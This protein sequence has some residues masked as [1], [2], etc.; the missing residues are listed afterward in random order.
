[1]LPYKPVKGA[2]VRGGAPPG[3]RTPNPLIKSTKFTHS[4]RH[5][6]GLCLLWLRRRVPSKPQ[7]TGVN[8]QSNGQDHSTLD[9]SR[10]SIPAT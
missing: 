8:G 6:L 5:Y 1:M 4:G 3:T 9:G 7:R 2:L 10:G